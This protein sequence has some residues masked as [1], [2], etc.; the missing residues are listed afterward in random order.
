MIS[1]NTSLDIIEELRSRLAAYVNEN[2][3]EWCSSAVLIDKMEY[4]NAIHLTI[5]MERKFAVYFIRSTISHM[6]FLS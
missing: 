1:Y 4:Q 2:N 5:V 6:E 3:R